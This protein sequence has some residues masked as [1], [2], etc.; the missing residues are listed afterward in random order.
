MNRRRVGILLGLLAGLASVAD[1]RVWT[2]DS[3]R[4]SLE[5]NLLAFDDNHVILQRQDHDLV[6]FPVGRLSTKDREYLQSKEAADVSNQSLEG[7]QTWTLAN[8]GKLVGRVVDYAQGQLAIQ[9]RRGRVY[10]NDRPLENLPE[11]YQLLLPQVVAHFENF[12]EG[13]RESFDRW[14]AQ[15]R[16]QRRTFALEGLVLETE[17]GDEFSVPFFLFANNDQALLKSG[18]QGWLDDRQADN[19]A[20]LDDRSFRLRSLAAARQRDQ[21]VQREIAQLQLMQ[22]V[23]AGVTSLWEVTLFPG[24]GRGGAPQW[25]V[26]PARDSRQATA[27]AMQQHPGFVAGPVRRVAGW[28]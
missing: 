17:N 5:A 3:G 1:A 11:F 18:Y 8:G 20:A 19:F 10:V 12:P 7:V 24:A 15:Q 16:G 9:R 2:D 26:V 22:A 25:V 14:I 27:A 28:R 13:T 21:Q 23:Q 4:Y 6:A